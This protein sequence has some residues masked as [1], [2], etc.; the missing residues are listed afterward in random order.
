MTGG[1]LRNMIARQLFLEVAVKTGDVIGHEFGNWTVIGPCSDKIRVWCKCK[2]GTIRPVIP[3]NLV[4]GKSHSCGCEKK[5]TTRKENSV[6]M[7]EVFMDMAKSGAKYAD[8]E[9]CKHIPDSDLLGVTFGNLTVV[10]SAEQ[11]MYLNCRCSCGRCIQ[12]AKYNL[13]YGH[14]TS[15]GC[16]AE[17]LIKSKREKHPV[18]QKGDK[19][20][21]LTVLEY[22]PKAKK[23]AQASCRC[24]CACGNEVTVRYSNLYNDVTKSCGCLKN[25]SG[26]KNIWYSSGEQKWIA[27]YW[28]K[29]IKRQ[30]VVAKSEDRSVVEQKYNNYIAERS[31]SIA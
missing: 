28:D 1:V 3:Y 27:V 22:I 19:F 31:A 5:K 13:L 4:Y 6:S 8:C 10:S 18:P 12:V 24:M 11:P 17:K 16:K 15:C 7:K 25:I 14:K 23:D 2:C 20:G 26:T 9:C 29:E 21:R 30:K